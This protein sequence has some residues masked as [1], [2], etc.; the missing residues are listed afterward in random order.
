[1]IYVP[2]GAVSYL[3]IPLILA[4]VYKNNKI[5]I[6][7]LLLSSAIH[8]GYSVIF[9]SIALISTTIS[10][11]LFKDNKK[12]TTILSGFLILLIVLIQNS[13]IFNSDAI[14]QI[15]I[16]NLNFKNLAFSLNYDF[17]FYNLIL[18]LS[19]LFE[20]KTILANIKKNSTSQLKNIRSKIRYSFIY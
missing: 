7:T 3:L 4:I 13:S 6:S 5:L 18:L 10:A 20:K 9:T 1:M 17:I 16:A 2:R 15:N 11:I 12:I 14:L 19:L 8:L